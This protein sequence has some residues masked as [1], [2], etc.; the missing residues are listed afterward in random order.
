ME[1]TLT[2]K[3]VIVT[4]KKNELLAGLFTKVQ[5]LFAGKDSG[6]KKGDDVLIRTDAEFERFEYDGLEGIF[7]LNSDL[8]IRCKVEKE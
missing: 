8:G 3:K 7:I 4:K 2:G 1:L 5:V 6:Y